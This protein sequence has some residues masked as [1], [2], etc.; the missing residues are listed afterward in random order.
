MQEK[1]TAAVIGATGL[2]GRALVRQ[3]L[4][5]PSFKEIRSLVRR[6][7]GLTHPKLK[8]EL[9]DFEQPNRGG[10]FHGTDV[11]FSVMGTTL[12]KAGSKEAQWRI[13]Y[14]YQFQ[15]AERAAQHGVKILVLVSAAGAD[16]SSRLF[17]SKMKGRLDE[18]VQQLAFAHVVILRPS[19]LDGERQESRPAERLGIWMGRCLRFLPGLRAFRAIPA[20][21]VA[22]AMIEAALKEK[23]ERVR[24]IS[25][26]DIF[27]EAE[28]R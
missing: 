15:T 2:V 11:L 8:E 3:L 6:P 21:T 14:D 10:D 24:V 19:V 25:L 20:E 16:S 28:G 9:F 22:S 4:E 13:D 26:G 18:A 1:L 17:Y 5:H 12:K 23:T 7:S 27:K